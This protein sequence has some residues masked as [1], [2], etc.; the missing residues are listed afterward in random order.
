MP[1]RDERDALLAAQDCRALVILADTSRDPYLAPFIGSARLSQA[2]IVAPRENVARLAYFTPMERLE[3]A[4]AGLPLLTPEELDVE[5][6]ARHGASPAE[7]QAHT[8]SRALQILGL[9]PPSGNRLALTGRLP[10]GHAG[11]VSSRLAAEGWSFIGGEEIVERLR[12]RKAPHEVTEVQRVAAAT[13]EAFRAVTRL[14]VAADQR[15]GELWLGGE[16]LRAR[17]LT[18]EIYRTLSGHGLEQPEGLLVA[19]GADGAVPHTTSDPD[20]VLRAG[21]PVVVDIFPRGRLFADC[22]RT[23]CYGPPPTELAEAHRAVLEALEIAYTATRPGRLGWEIQQT[24]CEHFHLTGYPTPIS[25]PGTTQGYVH[26]L[27][28]GVGYEVHEYPSFREHAGD[29]G[30]LRNDDVFTLEPGLYHPEN[31]WAVRLEDTVH[32]EDD[33]PVRLTDLPYDL[34]PRAWLDST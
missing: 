20:R 12:K 31:G 22:T 29:E 9:A 8:L 28:H 10:A 11:E 19:L 24:V 4:N 5:R 15:D 7:I 18:S 16:R 33:L 2:L 3:A 13:G 17:R 26:G 32:L 25:A 34:D 30:R 14:L 6:W 21:E 23:F 1:D 27:G